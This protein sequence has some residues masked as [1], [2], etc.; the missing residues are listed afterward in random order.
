MRENV[1]LLETLIGYWE[2]EIG[3]F[4]LQGETLEITVEDMYFITGISHRG[5]SINLEGNGM[6]GDPM[7]V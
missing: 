5:M 6:D 3:I 7:S 1:H 2:H 4:Y